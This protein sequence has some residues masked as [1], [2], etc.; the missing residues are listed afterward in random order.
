MKSAKDLPLGLGRRNF[1]S[2]FGTDYLQ[3]T[4][5]RSCCIGRRQAIASV[6]SILS[7]ATAVLGSAFSPGQQRNPEASGMSGAA[8][9]GVYAPTLDNK[10][11]PITAGGFVDGAPIIFEDITV[12]SGLAQFRHHCGNPEKKTIL[13]VD[14]SGV[15][16]I[17]YDND[18]W[19]DIYLLNGSTL[20]ALKGMEPAPRAMLLHNNRDGTFTD[21][22]EQSGVANERWGFGVAVGDFDNDGW[23]DMYI[24]NFG[25]NRLYRNNH[26]GTFT[27][28]A[29]KAGVAVGGWSAGPT[30]GDYDRDGLLDLFVPGYVD[31]DPDHPVIAGEGGLPANYCQYRGVN[32]ICGPRGLKGEPDR[33]FHNNGDG[34]FSEVSEKAGVADEIGSYGWAS[35]FVDVDDDGW[36]DLIVANDSVPNYLYLNNHDGTFRDASYPS[37]FALNGDGRVVASMGIG[38]GDYN[39]DGKVDLF[40]TSFSDDYKPL[41]RNE[42]GGSF[43]DVTSDAGLLHPMIPFLGWGTGFLDFDNDG[44]LDLFIANGHVYPA[45]DKQNWG[46]TWAQRPLLFRNIN[47]SKFVEVPAATGS[48]LADVIPGRGAAFG[49]LFNDGRIDV[50][51]NCIDSKPALLRNVVKNNNHWVTLRLIGGPRSPRDGV[52]AKI[53]LTAG[54][55]RQRADVFSGGSYC[56]SSDQRVHFGLGAANRVEELEIH[57]PSGTVDHIPITAIDGIYTVQEGKGVVERD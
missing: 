14:G 11:R 31:F 20:A 37:G 1:P 47:G 43:T 55:V 38:V 51:V 4:G 54:G 42:G 46:T 36:L 30:W 16:L 53:F 8:T 40:L 49:D 23:P 17:D 29:E 7:S 35:V 32:T 22:T 57:W 9:G 45:V 2:L 28:I 3:R 13:E 39:G 56:S 5:E 18:G 48:G 44:L 12:K 15:A 50:V 34:T 41:Y 52:G 10:K 25:Q 21:V 24:S 6:F 19:I 26:N 33:L 27:D